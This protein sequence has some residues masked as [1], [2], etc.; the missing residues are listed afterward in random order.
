MD[1]WIRKCTQPKNNILIFIVTT[2]SV[3]CEGRG[4]PHSIFPRDKCLNSIVYH[5]GTWQCGR[6]VYSSLTK[7]EVQ[8]DYPIIVVLN[9]ENTGKAKTERERQSV[10]KV[11]ERHFDIGKTWTWLGFPRN[12]GLNYMSSSFLARF[13]NR[14]PSSD[15]QGPDVCP[16]ET[17]CSGCKR[18]CLHFVYFEDSLQLAL[19]SQ[20]SD[21]IVS[22]LESANP[23]ASSLPIYDSKVRSTATEFGFCS[24]TAPISTI[25]S[26]V[27]CIRKAISSLPMI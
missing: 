19:P 13:E 2:V 14:N 8:R 4:I 22:S 1:D 12:Y 23:P 10:I 6:K 21:P 17:V 25:G 15:E 3:G 16:S 11:N 20:L 27:S 5:P 26:L 7:P 18:L 24:N 9:I